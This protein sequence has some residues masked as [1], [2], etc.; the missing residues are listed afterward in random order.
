M[1]RECKIKVHEDNNTATIEIY[2]DMTASAIKD[3][4]AARQEAF[5]H[6]L[7]SVVVKFDNTSRV[8][9]A[10]IVILINLVIDSRERGCKVY[11][12]GMSDHFR[13]IFQ[14][15]GL[16]KYAEIVESVDDIQAEKA[17]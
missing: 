15:V 8:N 16:T 3:M 2:G 1:R 13:K 5:G 10:G 6:K 17:D 11:L 4:D 14:L 7:S 12:T 9:T